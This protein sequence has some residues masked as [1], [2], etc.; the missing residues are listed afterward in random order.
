MVEIFAVIV[1]VGLAAIGVSYYAG[2][3]LTS[4]EGRITGGQ[5]KMKLY[6]QKGLTRLKEYFDRRLVSLEKRVANL[7][8]RAGVE[9]PSKAIED[10]SENLFEFDEETGDGEKPEGGEKNK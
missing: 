7:E 3:K 6:L 4:M 8:G 10:D 5:G 2:V 1:T 9:T